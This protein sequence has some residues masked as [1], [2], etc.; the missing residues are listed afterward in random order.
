[1]NPRRMKNRQS[2]F[3]ELEASSLYCPKCRE[4]VPVRKQL[5]LAL[6][7]GDKY[8]YLCTY[9]GSLV[10]NKTVTNQHA[11]DVIR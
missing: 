8:D 1:M 11:T 6:P 4:A 5:L 9:C 7:D 3:Q 2:S 10:G